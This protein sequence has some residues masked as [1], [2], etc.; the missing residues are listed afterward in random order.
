MFEH[1]GVAR[2]GDYFATLFALLAPTGR[3]LN[4]A[5]SRPPGPV[6]SSPTRSS[7][8]TCSPTASCRRWDQW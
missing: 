3:L 8:A 7:S 6:A 5:I 4:H 1:V 2:V